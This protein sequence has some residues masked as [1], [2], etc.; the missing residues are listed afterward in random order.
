MKPSG[1][2]ARICRRQSPACDRIT[3]VRRPSAANRMTSF[4]RN[5]FYFMFHALMS[6]I[7]VGALLG[8]PIL[9]MLL[10]DRHP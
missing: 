1:K 5:P 7:L 9:L 3:A 10:M 8:G 6:I 4:G 2:I